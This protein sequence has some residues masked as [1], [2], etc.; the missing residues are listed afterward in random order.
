[1]DKYLFGQGVI[2]GLLLIVIFLELK[3]NAR[4]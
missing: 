2:V 4:H 3:R 1:M